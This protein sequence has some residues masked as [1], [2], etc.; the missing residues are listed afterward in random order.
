MA[1]RDMNRILRQADKMSQCKATTS[2]DSLN[3]NYYCV[4]LAMIGRFTPSRVETGSVHSVK[5]EKTLIEKNLENSCLKSI[6]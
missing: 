6:R 4:A 5:D 1:C 2:S 3:R